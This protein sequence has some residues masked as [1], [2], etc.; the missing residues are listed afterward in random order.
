VCGR[1]LGCLFGVM[2]LFVS[3]CVYVVIYVWSAVRFGVLVDSGGCL[4]V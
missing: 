3:V 2:G 1:L 4:M